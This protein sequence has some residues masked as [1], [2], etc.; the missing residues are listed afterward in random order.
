M[1]DIIKALKQ[2]YFPSHRWSPLC[3]Q[4]GLLQLTLLSIRTKYQDHP[5][6]CLRECLTQW[7]SKVDKVTE[8]GG[9]TWDSL[10]DA[11]KTIEFFAVE[12]IKGLSENL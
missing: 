5:E 10:A 8:S 1:K 6:S 9:P 12:Q 2:V 7:L 4:L 11:V 3:L